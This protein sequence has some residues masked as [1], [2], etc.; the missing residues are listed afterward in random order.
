MSKTKPRNFIHHRDRVG[1]PSFAFRNSSRPTSSDDHRGTLPI[2]DFAVEP[3]GF[4][5]C[6]FPILD[7]DVDE[8]VNGFPSEVV[9]ACVSGLRLTCITK[10]RK[11]LATSPARPQTVR[12]CLKRQVATTTMLRLDTLAPSLDRVSPRCALSNPSLIAG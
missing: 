7:D 11:P 6:S 12:Y 1:P 2:A 8:T 10:E 3:N 4:R 9:R 5:Y